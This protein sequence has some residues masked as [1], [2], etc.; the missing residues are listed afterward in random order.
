MD[1][2]TGDPAFANETVDYLLISNQVL[3][4]LLGAGATQADIDQMMVINPQRFFGGA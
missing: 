2:M 3:P 4:A 1:F